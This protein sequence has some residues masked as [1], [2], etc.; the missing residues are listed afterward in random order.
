MSARVITSPE[1]LPLQHGY[2]RVFLG[3]SIDMGSAADWQK[4]MIESLRG[5]DVV[6]LNPR[7]S[8]WNPAWKPDASNP[9]FRQ[10]VKWELGALE[11]A[12]VIV[13]YFLPGSQSPISLLGMG[14]HAKSG[15][16]IVLCP[17][18]YWRKGNVD[19][20]ASRYGIVQVADI[21]ELKTAVREKLRKLREQQSV[22]RR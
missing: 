1:R 2:P 3:G 5:E 17:Q 15:K 7:R 9:N 10:Q 11:S 21:D 22:E 12:H 19:I 14:L 16:L 20:T 8:D 4:D 18:G 13:L 6:I